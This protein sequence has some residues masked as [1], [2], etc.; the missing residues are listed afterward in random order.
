MSRQIQA[1][2][3]S[4]ERKMAKT[5]AATEDANAEE[6][7]KLESAASIV[8]RYAA[9]SAAV[10]LVPM[11]LVD[12]TLISALQSKM[13]HSLS[14]LYGVPFSSQFAKAVLASL[15]G[16]VAVDGIGRVGLGSL[17]KLVPG[18]GHIAGALAMP[19]VAW[20]A[21]STVGQIFIRHFESG[22][23]LLDLNLKVWR[24]VYQEKVDATAKE[25]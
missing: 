3:L 16:S 10:G 18:V 2:H 24:P 9:A 1:I 17:L 14:N 6:A 23:T 19:G 13:I 22:G 8:S 15:T 20:A 5:A 25:S 12:I 4:E 21:T 7:S 11:P